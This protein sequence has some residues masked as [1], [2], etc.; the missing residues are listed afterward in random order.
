MDKSN[1]DMIGAKFCQKTKDDLPQYVVLPW[2]NDDN[3]KPWYDVA[4]SLKEQGHTLKG[5][6]LIHKRKAPPKQAL[7]TLPFYLDAKIE[8]FEDLIDE[9]DVLVEV[10]GLWRHIP[11]WKYKACE[12]MRKRCPNAKLWLNEYALKNKEYWDSTMTLAQHLAQAKLIDGVG[13]QIHI[14]LRGPWRRLPNVAQLTSRTKG[15][16]PRWAKACDYGQSHIRSMLTD[17]RM[18][19]EIGRIHKLGLDAQISELSVTGFS[20]QTQL[21][22]ELEQRIVDSALKYGASV[23]RWEDM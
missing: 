4:R 15:K 7:T 9:W 1:H 2:F 22:G 3:Y 17:R 12:H 13:I 8:G 10:R 23:I 14:D 18:A 21:C 6:P 16:L 5:H 19:K 20:D 11:G